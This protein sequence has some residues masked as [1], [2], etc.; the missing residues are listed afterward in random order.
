MCKLTVDGNIFDAHPGDLLFFPAGSRHGAI[1]TG[2]EG[3][4]HSEIFAPSRPDQ[5]PGGSDHRSCA[6]N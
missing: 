3:C 6:M 2:P 1:G 5:L 4:V